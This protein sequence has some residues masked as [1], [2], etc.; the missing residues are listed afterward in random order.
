MNFTDMLS[1]IILLQ[2]HVL[3]PQTQQGVA[4]L[5]VEVWDFDRIS[6]DFLGNAITDESGFF[7]LQIHPTTYN[8]L[9]IDRHPDLYFQI[10]QGEKC[11][12]NT[13]K[14]VIWNVKERRREVEI[15]LDESVVPGEGRTP[16][17]YAV[18]GR[19]VKPDGSGI[20]NI[21]VKAFDKGNQSEKVLGESKT[22][23]KGSY[24]IRYTSQDLID[25]T[26]GR[27]DL[28]VRAFQQ[29][30]G[31]QVAASPL[32]LNAL[33]Q[34]VV[35]LVVGESVFRGP[36]E[37][38]QVENA[39]AELLQ[40]A[41]VNEISERE[42]TVLANQSGLED[43]QVARYIKASRDTEQ[44][45]V[46]TEVLYGLYAQG[47]PTSL[48]ALLNQQPAALQNALKTA[49]D[50]NEIR[51]L[52]DRQLTALNRQL[53]ESRVL[54]V[55]NDESALGS[56]VK[57]VLDLGNLTAAEQ[58]SFVQDYAK[59]QG[60]M[61][62]F[63]DN[64]RKDGIGAAKVESLQRSLQFAAISQNHL[65]MVEALQ[66]RQILDVRELA[67]FQTNDW[68][69]LIR[70]NEVGVPT[71]VNGDDDTVREELYA[72][73]LTQVVEDAFP[74]AV[75]ANR[76]L[77][78]FDDNDRFTS[79][80]LNH[81]TFEFR[82][83]TVTRYLQDNP[84]TLAGIADPESFTQ[85][86]RGLE[87]LFHVAPAYGKF[88]RLLP[89]WE[90]G[91]R[92]ATA[93]KS[94]GQGAFLRRYAPGNGD[95][96][97]QALAGDPTRTDY[98]LVY[99][100]AVAVANT[101]MNAYFN[102][103]G[104]LQNVPMYV[105]PAH[106]APEVD[107]T[108]IADLETIFGS[109][110]FCSCEHCESVLSPS[111]YLV[112]LLMFL[113]RADASDGDTAL[114]KL[115]ARRPDI[116]NIDLHCE[117]AL[118]P[119]PYLDLVNE[120]LENAIVP[121]TYT[122]VSSQGVNLPVSEDVPQTSAEAAVLAANPENI[123]V[124]AYERLRRDATTEQITSY[125][126]NLPFNLW[127]E[128][129][130]TYLTHLGMPRHEL[131]QQFRIDPATDAEAAREYLGIIPEMYELITT[132]NTNATAVR[133]YWGLSSGNLTQLNDVLTFMRQAEIEYDALKELLQ[134]R[135]IQVDG[136]ALYISFD[137][138]NPCSLTEAEIGGWTTANRAT[139]LDRIHRFVRLQRILGWQLI[140]LDQALA[141]LNAPEITADVITALAGMHALKTDFPKLRF[142]QF[143]SWWG[144][145]IET[146][147]YE[148][149]A[150]L[151][152]ELF[153][154]QAVNNPIEE[155]E[156]IFGLNATRDEL[157]ATDKS[158]TDLQYSPLVQAAVNLSEED[159]QAIIEADFGGDTSL[160]LAHLSQLYRI[161]LFARS[162]KLS[163]TDYLSLREM[164]GIQAL[165]EGSNAADPW[166]SFAFVAL[167]NE[168]KDARIE[169]EDLRYILLHRFVENAAIATDEVEIGLNLEELRADLQKLRADQ[170]PGVDDDLRLVV[171]QN[172]SLV[173]QADGSQSLEDKVQLAMAIIDRSSTQSNADQQNFIVNELTFLPDLLDAQTTLLTA[174]PTSEPAT[175]NEL[176]N[177]FNYI[178]N[179]LLQVLLPD[180]ME[181]LV[182]QK[183]SEELELDSSLTAELLSV[184]LAHPS[185]PAQTAMEAFLADDFVNSE[186][187][188]K[189]A[190]PFADAFAVVE[191]VYKI[192]LLISQL[193]IQ[194]DD[195][196]F[197]MIDGPGIGW[198]DL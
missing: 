11:I 32:I 118:T 75:L 190:A 43:I 114:E 88:E 197:L 136:D 16:R 30:D 106:R 93:I 198:L 29:K 36:S 110:D 12:K 102:Y 2:G 165:R 55:L 158:L 7:S 34:E 171:Q 183:L 166:D 45:G 51:Q 125:P 44:S 57:G 140:E 22:D 124:D 38:T 109:Q 105:M 120:V 178:L 65:P 170:T 144:E 151:Y 103:G 107:E 196:T 185:L 21:V 174:L 98:Q 9:L 66:N 62:A 154:N 18:S 167:R 182:I 37:F 76:W 157:A 149:N 20:R 40:E 143:L 142:P 188:I 119:M 184:H 39:L 14:D 150:S 127:R 6:D 186:A 111:A 145:R 141:S 33:D 175:S 69:R 68:L 122:N 169:L 135:F 130:A 5:R 50:N 113:N 155:L 187:E 159:M 81:P 70:E 1:N 152:D 121:L 138:E 195:L 78:H 95:T 191:Q 87:R 82:S 77:N 117:N 64:Q 80:F 52:S 137:A 128:E 115:F 97:L 162:L 116:G 100:N 85:D 91:L 3:D 63:W 131:M 164:S 161:G 24:S 83:T 172:L 181:S 179:P 129:A 132:P 153:L 156:S 84:D 54:Q 193:G 173:L 58:S 25:L 163:I 53:S 56:R 94:M 41:N 71:T 27:A 74:T 112:D 133:G 67:A 10:Y 101:A 19:I 189:N 86:L 139:Y 180:L 17:L 49:V 46:G 79:F 176:S 177:R 72:R 147:A 123:N 90:D 26:K 126:W 60:E 104:I 13:R 42:I 48:G 194:N 146:H 35:N 28:V 89:L 59:H 31:S 4:D 134:V 8:R 192:S 23:V 148:G 61:S 92:S 15:V 108:G 96:S 168:L 73:R 160:N 47:Q 99:D